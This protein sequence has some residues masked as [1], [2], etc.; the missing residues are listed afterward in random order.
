MGKNSARL[1]SARSNTGVLRCMDRGYRQD[2][3]LHDWL[4]FINNDSIGFGSVRFGSGRVGFPLEESA[5]LLSMFGHFVRFLFFSVSQPVRHVAL[6][7]ATIVLYC[8]VL[9]YTAARCSRQKSRYALTVRLPHSTKFSS[10]RRRNGYD[11]D[12]DRDRDLVVLYSTVQYC[13]VRQKKHDTPASLAS[14]IECTVARACL[15]SYVY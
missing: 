14:S 2:K 11:R 5:L 10:T 1:G 13:T 6:I 7:S 15:A 3:R 9:E 8:T 4:I 12:C